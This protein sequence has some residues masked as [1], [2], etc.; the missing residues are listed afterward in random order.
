MALPDLIMEKGSTAV[1]LDGALRFEATQ[2]TLLALERQ[3]TEK[4]MGFMHEACKVCLTANV[5]TL[6]FPFK[7][8]LALQT[9]ILAFL[10]ETQV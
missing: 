10:K 3:K 4:Y 1:V 9:L 5:R 6:T 2:V 7:L 8:H